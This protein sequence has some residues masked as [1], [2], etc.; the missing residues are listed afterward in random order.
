[1]E[2]KI[3]INQSQSSVLFH[4][5]SLLIIRFPVHAVHRVC[6]NAIELRGKHDAT[7]RNDR[8][9]PTTAG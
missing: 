7:N 8:N 1:M 2:Q 4:F 9:A 3:Q 5:D 6:T